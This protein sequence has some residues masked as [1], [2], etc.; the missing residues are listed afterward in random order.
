MTTLHLTVIAKAPEPGRVKTRLC[1]PCTP[2]QAAAVALAALLDTFDALDQ[3]ATERAAGGR[4]VRRVLLIDGDPSSV[5]RDGWEVVVQRGDGL[6]ERLGCGFADL[7]PGLIIGMEAPAGGRWLGSALAS[8]ESGHDVVGLATDGG[9]W[10]IGLAETALDHPST[11]FDTVP[12]STSWTGLGQLRRLHAL[13]RSVRLLPMVRDLD[14]ADDL[15]AARA[16]GGRLGAI[17]RSL[18]T[19]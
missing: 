16:E 11:V 13:G 18:I 9:Y 2:E 14:D 17:A 3:V 6:G 8:L 19:D 10:M 5:V 7:G 12:M 15:R 1:P 4:H